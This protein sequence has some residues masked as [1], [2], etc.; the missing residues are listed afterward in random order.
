MG[1]I[2]MFDLYKVSTFKCIL[3]LMNLEVKLF[4]YI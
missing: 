2:N 3:A 1:S 4:L